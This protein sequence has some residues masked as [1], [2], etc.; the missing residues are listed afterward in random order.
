M[1]PGRPPGEAHLG[2]LAAR[3]AIT[4]SHRR[5]GSVYA[6][7]DTAPHVGPPR[8]PPDAAALIPVCPGPIGERAAAAGL[9]NW[10]RNHRFWKRKRRRVVRAP[11]HTRRSLR[12]CEIR[13][14]GSLSPAARRPD[15][16]SPAA[17]RAVA[18]RAASFPARRYHGRGSA[19]QAG[20]SR[21]WAESLSSSCQNGGRLSQ[22]P[23]TSPTPESTPESSASEAKEKRSRPASASP[24]SDGRSKI[25][26][27]EYSVLSLK[28]KKSFSSDL[29]AMAIG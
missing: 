15:R 16:Q 6:F 14:P 10:R 12:S 1:R 8:A 13:D 5:R 23:S 9:C 17:L 26:A 21:L 27:G 29:G 4:R 2:R 7:A 28:A 11:R 3:S 25:L 20:E 22:G 24:A 19:Q 18:C